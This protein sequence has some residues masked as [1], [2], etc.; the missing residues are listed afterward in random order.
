MAAAGGEGITA[1][2]VAHREGRPGAFN[3][4]VELVYPELRRIARRQL[5]HW[6][7][8]GSLD[9]GGVVHE[10]YL[11]L[12]DQTKVNW[13]DRQHFFAIA[14]RAMR[15]VIVDYARRRRSQKRGG[16]SDH[17]DLDSREIAVQ[18]QIV[19]LLAINELLG[20]LEEVDPRLLQVVECRFFAGYSEA[21]TAEALHVSSRTVERDWLRAKAWLRQTMDGTKSDASADRPA[22]R[23]RRGPDAT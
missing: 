2:L 9:T 4:L 8:G 12:I 16:G 5:G 23:P 15:H 19:E 14:A 22:R 13:Q 18:Q 20:K 3:Q 7:G 17:V 11:K 1:V 6:G 21:E 10:T